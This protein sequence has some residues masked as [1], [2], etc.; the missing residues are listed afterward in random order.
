MCPS[1]QKCQVLAGG[2]VRHDQP[3][4]VEDV[5][6]DQVVHV[7]AVARQQD[8]RTLSRRLAHPLQPLRGRGPARCRC[9]RRRTVIRMHMHLDVGDRE[10]RCDLLE[11]AANLLL[12]RP[13]GDLS[14]QRPPERGDG[15]PASR[16]SSGSPPGCAWPD[17]RI[18]SLDDPFLE[19]TAPCG[20]AKPQ[21]RGEDARASASRL[22]V[23]LD[24]LQQIDRLARSVRRPVA[25]SGRS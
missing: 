16:A 1:G 9:G 20:C 3:V 6:Q 2:D 7:A 23:L 10:I 22:G 14:G 24:E 5:A 21:P 15:P 13:P 19:S 8:E 17:F 12:D 11:V 25:G 4:R 18:G